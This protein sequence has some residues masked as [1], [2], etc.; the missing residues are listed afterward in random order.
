MA[1]AADRPVIFQHPSE[2]KLTFK[3]PDHPDFMTSAELKKDC[4]SG[5][6]NN[7]LTHE[8]EIWINGSIEAKGPEKDME[9]FRKAYA[10][11]FQLHDVKL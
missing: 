11:V 2:D 5:V 8:W 9:M 10:E 1:N 7:S 3:R 6:R 4:W